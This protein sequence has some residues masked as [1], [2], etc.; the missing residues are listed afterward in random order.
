MLFV[1]DQK[2]PWEEG[3][4]IPSCK[5]KECIGARDILWC[6]GKQGAHETVKTLPWESIQWGRKGYFQTYTPPK[7]EL[8]TLKGSTMFICTNPVSE[9]GLIAS[10]EDNRTLKRQ[11]RQEKFIF[12]NPLSFML[13]S[14]LCTF[15]SSCF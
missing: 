4:T 13:L 1:L 8:A 11:K 14:E 7:W 15:K 12:T 6:A 10:L 3:E 9:P 5:Q 2:E